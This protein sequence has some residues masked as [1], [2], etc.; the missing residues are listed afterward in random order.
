MSLC[1]NNHTYSN[2][3][4][5][6]SIPGYHCLAGPPWNSVPVHTKA[7]FSSSISKCLQKQNI[8][9][10]V[11]TV[12]GPAFFV[13]PARASYLMLCNAEGASVC[14]DPPHP[15]QWLAFIWCHW[16]C[17]HF[18]LGRKWEGGSKDGKADV[19]NQLSW[20]GTTSPWG[21]KTVC[22]L[23]RWIALEQWEEDTYALNQWY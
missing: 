20:N 1:T 11:F 23:S 15:Y 17:M 8:K 5:H 16:K 12:W 13:L 18:L 2:Q 10:S 7:V 3:S 21:K 9:G 14:E 6:L 4:H 19:A 22:L